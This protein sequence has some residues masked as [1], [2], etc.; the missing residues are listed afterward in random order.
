LL[1]HQVPI[2]TDHWEVEVAG[3]AEID[4]VSHSGSSASGEFAYSLNLTDIHSGWTETHALLDK[5]Q[6]AVRDALTEIEASL[7]FRLLGIDSDNGSE[8][9]N[10]HLGG[11][12]ETRQVQ[13]TRSRPYKKDDDAHIE[14]NNWTHVRKLLGWDRYDTPEAV[15]A[16]NDLYRNELRLW[17]NLYLPLVKLLKKLRVG[18]KLRRLY[19]PAETFLDRVPP[20]P[21]LEGERAALLK[22]QRE[23]LDPILRWRAPSNE[24][25]SEFPRWRTGV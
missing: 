5:S 9:I 16:I 22:S 14:Q 13:F 20:S 4:L 1:K 6:I 12:C 7:P 17:L 2:K 11:W 21:G 25:G 15:A 8:F 3:F 19:G 23:E 24:N 18:S 10:W